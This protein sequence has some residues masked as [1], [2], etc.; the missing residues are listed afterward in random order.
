MS[1][2]VC[3]SAYFSLLAVMPLLYLALPTDSARKKF[4]Y[5]VILVDLVILPMYMICPGAGPLYLLK[6]DFP[7]RALDTLPQ[8]R[9][10][11]GVPLNASPSGHVAWVLLM[12]WFAGQYC[13]KW[14]GILAG[15]F[16]GLTCI[17]TLGMGEH[18]VIDLVLAV[19]FARSI[20]ALVHRQW[21]IAGLATMV[22]LI[23]L[24]AFRLGWTVGIPSALAWVLTIVTIAPFAVGRGEAA[25][26]EETEVDGLEV[27]E[28]LRAVQ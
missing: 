13:K 16:A 12:S 24:V 14:A 27:R 6:G 19:P 15:V 3:R 5:A 7:W 2:M 18:Y 10:L 1:N 26:H 17:G 25:A 9:W 11:P 20:W 21:K 22:V 4:V 8:V 28:Q 23:W